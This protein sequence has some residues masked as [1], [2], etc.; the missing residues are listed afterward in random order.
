MNELVTNSFK[1]AFVG[2]ETGLITVTITEQEK[3]AFLIDFSDNG[4]GIPEEKIG[5]NSDSLGVDLIDSLVEQMNGE[6]QVETSDKG[7]H[8][9]IRFKNV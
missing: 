2:R 8:Y 4:V 3:G 7:T 6:L 9:N 1:H 5:G